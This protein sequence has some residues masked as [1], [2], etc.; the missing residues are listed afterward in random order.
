MKKI[1]IL[2]LVFIM[3]MTFVGCQHSGVNGGFGPHPDTIPKEKNNEELNTSS[4]DESQPDI[5]SIS[6]IIERSLS[7]EYLSNEDWVTLDT[8]SEE[9]KSFIKQLKEAFPKNFGEVASAYIE[10]DIII[11]FNL[12]EAQYNIN[13]S[14]EGTN[15][16]E[17]TICTIE[18]D[19]NGIVF[20]MP[21]GTALGKIENIDCILK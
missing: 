2:T 8:N 13:G 10:E 19:S 1:Y 18:I 3:I 17:V 16:K 5:S 11:K 21:Q 9:G 6:S 15:T 12:E 14:S 7:I 4:I 20:L